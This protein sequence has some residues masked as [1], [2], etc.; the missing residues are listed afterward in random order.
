MTRCDS[1]GVGDGAGRGVVVGLGVGVIVAAGGTQFVG[2]GSTG[3]TVGVGAADGVALQPTASVKHRKKGIQRFKLTSL[4][5]LLCCP[6]QG[7]RFS[8]CRH[9]Y[10][11]VAQLLPGGSAKP[12]A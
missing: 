7:E 5:A 9:S 6:V 4:D 2:V 12:I 10:V 8:A 1:I 3:C 11:F